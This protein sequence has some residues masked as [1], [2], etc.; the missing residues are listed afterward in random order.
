MLKGALKVGLLSTGIATASYNLLPAQMQYDTFGTVKSL[1]NFTRAGSVMALSAYDYISGLKDLNEETDEYYAERAQI[2]T[3]VANRILDLSLSNKGIYLKAGQYIGNLERVAPKEYT[4]VLRVLQDSGPQVPYSEIKTVFEFDFKRP[5]EEVFDKFEHKAIAAAS[6]AQVHKAEL[7]S[8]EQ[9]AVKL[10][11]PTL[12][13]QYTKDMNLLYI[14]V[15]ASDSFLKWYDFKGLDMT[16]IFQ[17]FRESLTD[18]LDFRKEVKNGEKTTELF[19]EN[20]NVFVPGYYK[21]FC[22][23]RVIT[24]E[25]VEGMKINDVAGIESLGVAKKDVSELLINSFAKMIFRHGHVHCDAHPG[26]FF[27]IRK[28]INQKSPEKSKKATACTSRPRIL[29]KL[30]RRICKKVLSALEIFNNRRLR[31]NENF[32]R[33]TR[34]W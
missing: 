24:M 10:Q 30:R 15:R 18:E 16:K 12:R 31:P 28:H 21:E 13:S 6:L 11:F 1:V 4:E 22:S 33:R 29:P 34:N 32:S 25:F 26:N 8:G 27:I 17:T 2:H 9:V 14:L 3:K 23:S 5:I 20:D 19:R 7:K